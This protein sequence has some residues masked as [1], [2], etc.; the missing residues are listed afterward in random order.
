MKKKILLVLAVLTVFIA[1][2]WIRDYTQKHQGPNHVFSTE[3]AI[4]IDNLHI[5]D[6]SDVKGG[7]YIYEVEAVFDDPS[8]TYE[9]HFAAKFKVRLN[10]HS[11]DMI[12][13]SVSTSDEEMEIWTDEKTGKTYVR[14]HTMFPSKSIDQFMETGCHVLCELE[15]YPRVASTNK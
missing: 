2:L 6:T 5:S 10:G 13:S 8:V 12:R 15:A 9:T 11:R 14:F 1:I 3:N 7:R 4:L